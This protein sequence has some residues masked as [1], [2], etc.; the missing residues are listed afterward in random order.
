MLSDRVSTV[1]SLEEPTTRRGE[2]Q[3]NVSK[4]LTS[5]ETDLLTG[6][7][8]EEQIFS[9]RACFDSFTAPG[10]V[11]FAFVLSGKFRLPRSLTSKTRDISIAMMTAPSKLFLH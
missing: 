3:A 8:T 1:L 4:Y 9:M 6:D 2:R 7:L 5:E 10:S 11:Q